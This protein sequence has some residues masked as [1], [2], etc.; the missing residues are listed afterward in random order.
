MA[1]KI[2]K[3]QQHPTTD[4]LYFRVVQV[5]STKPYR[6]KTL[7]S[8]GANPPIETLLGACRRFGCKLPRRMRGGQ[9]QGGSDVR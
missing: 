5:I 8:L 2:M 9:S 1:T 7:K 3:F 6:E 4:R